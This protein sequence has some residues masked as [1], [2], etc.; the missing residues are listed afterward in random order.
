MLIS[1]GSAGFSPRS[2]AATAAAQ[3]LACAFA[4]KADFGIPPM[5][6]ASPITWMFGISF[7]SNVTGSTGH[8]PERSATPALCAI[9]AARCG[10][11]TFAT[12]A[13]WLVKSVTRVISS[14]LTAFTLPPCDSDTHSR[15]SG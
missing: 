12:V 6:A 15:W 8:Q 1:R 5:M 7:D 3:T 10:G 11:M 2:S 4:E 14:A 9:G 13:L